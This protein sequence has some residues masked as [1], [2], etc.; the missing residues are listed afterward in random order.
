M[1]STG[2]H[3]LLLKLLVYIYS[4]WRTFYKNN[5]IRG[6]GSIFGLF[7]YDL[8]MT[9]DVH[10]VK[11]YYLSF[12][13]LSCSIYISNVLWL[14]RVHSR[15][16]VKLMRDTPPPSWKSGPLKTIFEPVTSVMVLALLSV[17]A[18]KP[19]ILTNIFLKTELF[20]N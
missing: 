5:K 13:N 7:N 14:C 19:N 18:N 4:E 10:I 3:Q 1:W 9:N 16:W 8:F 17:N 2:K 11:W 15:I 12:G 20:S 6:S